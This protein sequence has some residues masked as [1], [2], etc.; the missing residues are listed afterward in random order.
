MLGNRVQGMHNKWQPQSRYEIAE[1]P[2]IV[3][4]MLRRV[5][6]FDSSNRIA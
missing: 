4:E 3:I 6:S 1:V 5:K 2:Q